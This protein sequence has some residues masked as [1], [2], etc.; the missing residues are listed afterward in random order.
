[1]TSATI[2][3]PT[4]ESDNPMKFTAG[5]LLGID[6]DCEIQNLVDTANVRVRVKYPDQ[7]VHLICPRLSNFRS[8]TPDETRL[9]TPIN[10]SH[11]VSR[12][13]HLLAPLMNN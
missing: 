4:G 7:Q 9:L 2:I 10:V 3:E 1:M 13:L 11:Q 8:V 12:T 5:L 6:L